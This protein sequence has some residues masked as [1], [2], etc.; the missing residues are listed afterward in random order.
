MHAWVGVN[1]DCHQP[2]FIQSTG[3]LARATRS[4]L[5]VCRIRGWTFDDVIKLHSYFLELS[6]LPEFREVRAKYVNVKNPPAST[7]VQVSRLFRPEFLVES[8]RS[9]SSRTNE[10][11]FQS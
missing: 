1:R 6:R 10:G 2:F 3:G 8:Q 4:R 9:Q 5:R 11:E 7:A